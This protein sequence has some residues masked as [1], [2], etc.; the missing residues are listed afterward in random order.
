VNGRVAIA[1][2]FVVGGAGVAFAGAQP[3][4]SLTP[5][6]AI[7]TGEGSARVKGVVEA[8]DRANGTFTLGGD[9]SQLPV[10]LDDVP[11]AVT[12][13]KAL[14]AEGEL[15]LVDG[16]TVLAAEDIQLGCPSKYEA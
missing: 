7:E 13:G 15:E 5:S 10:A 14:L 6:E 12:P 9:G 3:Q 16:E 11:S 4:A 8:V 2:V 1:L